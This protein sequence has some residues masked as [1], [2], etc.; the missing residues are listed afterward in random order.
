MGKVDEEAAHIPTN[1]WH[2]IEAG[3]WDNAKALVSDDFKGYLPQTNES[4]LEPGNLIELLRQMLGKP[5]IQIHNHMA[6]YDVW[7][8]NH[9]VA[10]QIHVET[11]GI[12]ASMRSRNLYILAFFIVDRD[13]LITEISLYFAECL[14]APESRQG[15]TVP[16]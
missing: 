15:L 8:K 11:R 7:D 16:I 6:S 10:L 2:M 9:Q 3:D 14:P 13:Y 1:F 12:E 5:K 4:I